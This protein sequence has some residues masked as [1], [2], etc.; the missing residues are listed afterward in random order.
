MKKKV[1]ALL[2]VALAGVTNSAVADTTTPA[3]KT[4]K[5]KVSQEYKA[6]LDKW[7][8]DNK[9]AADAFKSAM[10]DYIAKMKA[11]KD[12]HQNANAA[13]KSAVDAAKSA[14]KS[15]MSSATTA[16]A[17]SAAENARKAAIAAAAAPPPEQPLRALGQIGH[18][19]PVHAQWRCFLGGEPAEQVRQVQP[20]AEHVVRD[21]RST[22]VEHTARVDHAAALRHHGLTDLVWLGSTAVVVPQVAA[23]H[24]S[25]GTHLSRELGDGVHAADRHFVPVG[26]TQ[27]GPV[28]GIAVQHLRAFAGT[29]DHHLPG[30]HPDVGSVR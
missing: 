16:E 20:V 8:A 25:R 4:P 30:V 21:I 23:G 6:A 29:D 13:F 18:D 26:V 11:N 3:P 17:K 27:V 2:I 7:R 10:A 12:A 28:V 19:L 5:A 22:A 14:F 15:A 1:A 24:H 9:V